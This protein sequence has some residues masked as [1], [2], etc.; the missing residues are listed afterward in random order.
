MGI[1]V[2]ILTGDSLRHDYMRHSFSLAEGVEVLRTYRETSRDTLL[3]DARDEGEQIR[4]K[5]LERRAVSEHDF[6][7]P[8]TSHAPDKSNPVD[9][10]KGSINDENRYEEIVDMDP[11][12]LLTYGSSIIKD[13]LLS[14]YENCFLNCHLGLSPYYRGTGTNFW[15]LVNGE[16]EYV[17]ATFHYLVEEVDAGEIIH[18]LR[19]S[20][21]P[22][23]G[24][25]DI[26]HR[27]IADAGRIYPAI[28]RQFGDLQSLEQPP[29]PEDSH[30]YRSSDYN[31]QAT[32]QLYSNFADGMIDKYIA[33]HDDRVAAA[34]IVEQ[35]V[36]DEDDLL[37]APDLQR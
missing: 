12:L 1:S 18:Q 34:P 19:A 32:R 15:P 33:E 28:A 20:V 27:L 21:Y 5:H 16:P 35:P 4:I 9:I 26:G 6:F 23:D 37:S 3:K 10:P 29:E 25:H 13:P 11:D 31:P 17:G 7:A 22:N 36:L 8:F 30:Y 14:E 24:P 2:V